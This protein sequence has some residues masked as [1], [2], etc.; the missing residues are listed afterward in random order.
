MMIS[1]I[2]PFYNRLDYLRECL[3]SVSKQSCKKFECILID[4]G[5]TKVSQKEIWKL[6]QNYQSKIK[7]VYKR[8]ENGGT[9]SARNM[10]I[11]LSKGSYLIF[12]DSDDL[13]HEYRIESDF[14]ILSEVDYDLIFSASNL[15]KENPKDFA[16]NKYKHKQNLIS[17]RKKDL[18]VEV[19]EKRLFL[20]PCSATIKKEII[21]NDCM[22]KENIRYGEDFDF[23]LRFFSKKPKVFYSSEVGSFYRQSIHGKSKQVD[24]KKSDLLAIYSYFFEN[25]DVNGVYKKYKKSSFSK[26]FQTIANDYWAERKYDLF[27]ENYFQA[28]KNSFFKTSLKTHLRFLKSLL[29]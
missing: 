25:L 20:A 6:L 4:D 2:I 9:A 16:F 7:L 5:S 19:L 21:Y 27:R 8:K 15:F 29:K 10:G 13:L 23:W 12:L 28:V 17:V 11:E 14:K 26:G 1:I 3:D 22:F 24:Q 18:L